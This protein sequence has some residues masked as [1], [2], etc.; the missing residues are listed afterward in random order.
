MCAH[1]SFVLISFETFIRNARI[2]SP[3]SALFLSFPNTPERLK[4]VFI[5]KKK[6]KKTR[7]TRMLLGEKR[8]TGLR[9]V[10][11]D[12]VVSTWLRWMWPGDKKTQRP[13]G[14]KERE[15]MPLALVCE[16]AHLHCLLPTWAIFF[17]SPR[18]P[19]CWPWRFVLGG[20]P[21]ATVTSCGAP[22]QA[23]PWIVTHK[24]G[25]AVGSGIWDVTAQ[26]ISMIHGIL[27]EEI[28]S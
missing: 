14:E 10:A 9:G 15:E 28:Q 16:A 21:L 18:S 26:S 19:A 27:A 20:W 24:C 25:Q 22:K 7:T 13:S 4:C 3:P 1:G 6:K 11:K 12:D 5:T 17:H 2:T 23:W 8:W